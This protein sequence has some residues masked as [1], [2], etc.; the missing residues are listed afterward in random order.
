MDEKTRSRRFKIWG[1][2]V[3]STPYYSLTEYNPETKLWSNFGEQPIGAT[4]KWLKQF[5]V[6][7][8]PEHRFYMTYKRNEVPYCRHI[9]SF[10][11]ENPEER[12]WVNPSSN[13]HK[14]QT[15]P[16]RGA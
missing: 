4:L 1:S 13:K 14:T 12:G 8:Y 2:W 15:K 10:P 7:K 16:L 3:K 9:F 6:E 11:V 5:L